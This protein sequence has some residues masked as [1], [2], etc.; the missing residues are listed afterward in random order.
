MKKQFNTWGYEAKAVWVDVEKLTLALG[1]DIICEVK[2]CENTFSLKITETWLGDTP[3]GLTGDPDIAKILQDANEKIM[4]GAGA[5]K[6][7]GKG[8]VKGSL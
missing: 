1:G 8:K 7:L 2:L 4:K 5:T 3:G 6:G